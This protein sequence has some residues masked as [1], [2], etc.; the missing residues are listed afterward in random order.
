MILQLSG[1]IAA[2]KFLLAYGFLHLI[3]NKS[4]DVISVVTFSNV[5]MER[6]AQL[7]NEVFII[8]A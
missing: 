8:L 4:L 1:D 3:L 6:V 7:R 5:H 2:E